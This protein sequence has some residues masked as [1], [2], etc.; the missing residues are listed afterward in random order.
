[1]ILTQ[2]QKTEYMQ[3]G[4]QHCPVC[5]SL[6]ISGGFV[7]VAGM[8]AW[9]EVSCNE[10]DARWQDVYKLAFVETQDEFGS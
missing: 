4:A 3:T 8:E 1:M 2:E 7:E 6:D 5:K 9:Q 10:C